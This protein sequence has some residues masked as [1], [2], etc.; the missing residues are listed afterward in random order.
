MEN[1]SL[2]YLLW[3]ALIFIISGGFIHCQWWFINDIIV[4]IFLFN[5]DNLICHSAFLGFVAYLFPG[6][7]TPAFG[8]S[9][10]WIGLG[11]TTGFLSSYLSSGDES[12]LLYLLL[13]ICVVATIFYTFIL[14]TTKRMEQVFL[15]S[16]YCP[17]RVKGSPTNGNT[18]VLNDIGGDTNNNTAPMPLDDVKTTPMPLDDVKTT[19]MPLLDYVK[20]TP[21]PLDDVK[22]TPMPLYWK[23][24][25]VWL[26]VGHRLVYVIILL[27]IYYVSNFII[28]QYHWS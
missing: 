6:D 9:R 22:T 12:V 23:T 19:P 18:T 15:Y 13:V 27:L 8:A 7:T 3:L 5:F 10:L 25:A 17:K 24:T 26:C 1:K 2:S 11:L 20:T 14:F 28:K 16:V 4:K 21:I